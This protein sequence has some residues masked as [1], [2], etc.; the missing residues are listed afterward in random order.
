V[1]RLYLHK[2]IAVCTDSAIF[3][4]PRPICANLRYDASW[5][6]CVDDAVVRA[7]CECIEGTTLRHR[8]MNEVTERRPEVA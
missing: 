7:I 3:H 1:R 5:I 2:Q 4:L 6:A 8:H